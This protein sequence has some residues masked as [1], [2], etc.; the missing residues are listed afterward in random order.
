[1]VEHARPRQAR[2]IGS[3][4]PEVEHGGDGNAAAGDRRSPRRGPYGVE[5]PPDAD[6]ECAEDDHRCNEVGAQRSSGCQRHAAE[7]EHQPGTTRWAPLLC[8]AQHREHADRKRHAGRHLQTAGVQRRRE[9]H[10][11]GRHADEEPDDRQGVEHPRAARAALPQDERGQR[12]Q[13]E[14]RSRHRSASE[15]VGGPSCR[16]HTDGGA[17]RYVGVGL[18]C[19]HVRGLACCAG[20]RPGALA[21]G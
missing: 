1:M 12:E 21:G 14:G 20:G 2:L 18:V 6:Q 15:Q 16:A 4:P 3:L 17:D 8:I 11:H 7:P 13:G 10:G 9:E 5:C 19:A